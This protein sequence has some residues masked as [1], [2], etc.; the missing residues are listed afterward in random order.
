MTNS[1]FD[2]RVLNC[3]VVYSVPSTALF[4]RVPQLPRFASHAG[5]SPRPFR[6][7]FEA[8]VSCYRFCNSRDAVN[9]FLIPLD[10]FSFPSHRLVSSLPYVAFF[11]T[12]FLA[13]SVGS[14]PS[15]G[16]PL[17]F[18][19]L[20]WLRTAFLKGFLTVSALAP[21]TRVPVPPTPPPV[22]RANF[23][24][25]FPWFSPQLFLVLLLDYSSHSPPQPEIARF[26]VG[27]L[28]L[29]CSGATALRYPC[30]PGSRLARAVISRVSRLI[31][32]FLPMWVTLLFLGVCCSF[33][34]QTGPVSSLP[35]MPLFAEHFFF[36]P[37][38]GADPFPRFWFSPPVHPRRLDF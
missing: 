31:G 19:R 1:S 21:S 12:C 14:P 3:L 7:I 17:L 18:F 24:S 25:L 26:Y 36:L 32:R 35:L 38:R 6:L 29:P 22:P 4:R 30:T 10:I 37:P 27:P 23:I 34:V 20:S 2:R 15:A 16:A 9:L 33:P 5:W 8:F 28:F 11:D 13:R